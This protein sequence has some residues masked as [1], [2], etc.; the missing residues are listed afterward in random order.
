MAEATPSGQPLAEP[1]TA[2]SKRHVQAVATTRSTKANAPAP[3]ALAV[4]EATTSSTRATPATQMS[5]TQA[6]AAARTPEV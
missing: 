1:T 3:V 4:Q 5:A 6:R 2:A